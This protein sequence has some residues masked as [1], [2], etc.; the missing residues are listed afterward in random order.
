MDYMALA[1]V[2][3]NEIY[4]AYMNKMESPRVYGTVKKW[5]GAGWSEIASNIADGVGKG[6]SAPQ[7]AIGADQTVY[8]KWYDYLV[9]KETVYSINES[10]LVLMDSSLPNAIG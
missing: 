8:L 1:V 2:D 9:S 3:N 7:L 10:S 6:I 5:D 4:V